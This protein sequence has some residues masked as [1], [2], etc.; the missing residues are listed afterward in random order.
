MARKR[1]GGEPSRRGGGDI[2]G[3]VLLCLAALLFAALFSF[4]KHDLPAVMNPPNQPA[5]NWVGLFG[6]HVA[7]GLFFAVG[8]SAYLLPMLL[9]GFGLAQFLAP[10]RYLR[11]RWPWALALMV[12]CSGAMDLWTDPAALDQLVRQV[13]DTRAGWLEQLSYNLNAPS[14]GGVLG[15]TLNRYLIGYFG[16]LGGGLIYFTLYLIALYG[17]TNFH[18]G[19]WLRGLFARLREWWANRQQSERAL[20]RRARRLERQAAKLKRRLEAKRARRQPAEPP[21][22]PVEAPVAADL[23]QSLQLPEPTV[24]DLSQPQVKDDPAPAR[25]NPFAGPAD[26]PAAVP[27]AAAEPA[28]P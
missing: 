15:L 17:L 22:T 18:L 16:R 14:A 21:P 7:N 8:A 9:F 6:A 3:L 25:D 2:L 12:A 4:D 1:Q 23:A 19:D 10:L 13:P 27:T 24:R 11:H 26:E 28:E 20:A 5:R